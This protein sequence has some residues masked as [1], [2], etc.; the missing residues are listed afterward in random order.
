M[1]RMGCLHTLV[2][3]LM[4]AGA[5][6]AQLKD[7]SNIR[8]SVV[9][10][11]A[12]QRL[13]NWLHPWQSQGPERVFGTGAVIEGNR[14]LT[15]AHLVMYATQVDVQPLQ[16]ADTLPAKVVGLAPEMDLAVL[17]VD[18]EAFFEARP[19]LTMA[20]DLPS[21]RETVSAYGYPI[22]GVGLSITRGTVSR[23]EFGTYAYGETGLRIEISAAV[24]PGNS[25]GP[26]IVNDQ[27]VGLVFGV[28][29]PAQN[30]AYL[31]PAEEIRLFLEDIRDG[32]YDGK[33]RFWED[34]QLLRNHSLRA[35]L[36]LP[37]ST[38]G[39][40]VRDPYSSDADYPLK[41]GDV[42]T[43]VGEH[44]I[45]NVG[46]VRVDD[47]LRL[48]FPYLLPKLARQDKVSL[49]IIRQCK[50]ITVDY[51][52]RQT[53]MPLL[54]Y[55]KEGKPSYFIWG[56]L[57]FSSA[58]GELIDSLE[59]LAPYLSAVWALRSSPLITRRNDFLAFEGEELVVVTS[60][61]PHRISDGYTNATGQVVSHVNGVPIRNLHHLVETL[62]DSNDRFVE[63]EFADK[64]VETLI[65]NRN[66]A[67]AATAEILVDNGIREQV[68]KDLRDVWRK[69][70]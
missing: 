39:V 67:Q 68:S 17:A 37:K 34:V 45:D 44:Q 25:G 51:P 47:N 42:I 8:Q 53:H 22:G 3:L 55:L 18:D 15:N 4:S 46:M 6:Q 41:K 69:A 27:M 31:I 26:A 20:G 52:A 16:A 48:A 19:T 56:P 9:R 35:S 29:V 28:A 24:N 64:Y 33:P 50:S 23:I 32:R 11:V 38:T 30:T 62:R 63:F 54:R 65:F 10:I 70:K 58:T 2:L 40:L 14:I 5:S 61:F 1:T 57:A 66:E 49:N 12:T 7:D 36:G 59:T 60:M 21:I 43:A 13:P